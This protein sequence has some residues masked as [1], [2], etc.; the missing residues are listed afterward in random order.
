MAKDGEETWQRRGTITKLLLEY[1][2]KEEWQMDKMKP[3][4]KLLSKQQSNR[5]IEEDAWPSFIIVKV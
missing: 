5:S 2:L 1:E 4:W 3:K